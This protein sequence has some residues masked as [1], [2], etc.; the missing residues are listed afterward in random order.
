MSLKKS[1][2]LDEAG[3]TVLNKDGKFE[4]V[5]EKE[6][7]AQ[8]IKNILLTIQGSD[9]LAPWFGNSLLPSIANSTQVPPELFIEMCIRKA[10]L[11]ENEPRIKETEQLFVEEVEDRTYKV[12][13]TVRS[14]YDNRTTIESRLAV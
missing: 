7:F 13:L 1:L 6:N 3:N 5:E 14:I 4:W 9:M 2:K 12:L 11:P 8:V 10:L